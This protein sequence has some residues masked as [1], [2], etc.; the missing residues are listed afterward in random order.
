M[1]LATR[2][3]P[4]LSWA[5][6]DSTRNARVLIFDG[7][8]TGGFEP[9]W[10]L[11]VDQG[12]PWLVL[13]FDLP[14]YGL[15]QWCV[16]TTVRA[17]ERFRSPLAELETGPLD[18]SD[19]TAQWVSVAVGTAMTLS[20]DAAPIGL[21][22]R[23][24]LTGQGLVRAFIDGHPV[25]PHALDPSRTDITRALY[26]T[27]DVT[28]LITPGAHRLDLAVGRG[29]WHTTGF[30]PR[31]LA[32]LR[33]GAGHNST[34]LTRT[35]A[36]S[37]SILSRVIVDEPYYREVHDLRS[38]RWHA[39]AGSAAEAARGHLSPTGMIPT[40]VLP[41]PGPEIGCS[42]TLAAT[43]L[44]SADGLTRV[45]D[46]GVNIAGTSSVRLRTGTSCATVRVV[47][48]EHRGAD[49]RVDTTNLRL[50][51]DADRER[52]VVEYIVDQGEHLLEPWFSYHGFRYVEITGV[53]LDTPLHV[54][55]H[56]IHSLIEPAVALDSDSPTVVRLD[57]VARRTL[58]NTV[59]GM[60]E[61]CPTREQAG[62]TGDTAAVVEYEFAAFDVEA[63]HRKWLGDL[64][65]SQAANGAVPA[66]APHIG[67]A[68]PSDPVWGAALPRV[69]HAHWMRYGDPSVLRDH[70]PALRAWTRFLN[71]C[72]DDRGVVANAPISY[73]HDWLGLRQTPPALLHTAA[74]IEAFEILADLEKY[75]G[76]AQA[77]SAAGQ[78]ARD[79]R[80]AARDVFVR[81]KPFSV[82]NGSQG[83][84]ATAI[85]ANLL[86]EGERRTAGRRL[87]AAIRREGGRLTSGFAATR[88]VVQALAS[89]GADQV[90]FDLL[91]MREEPGVGAMLGNSLGTFWECWWIDPMNTGTGSLDHIGLG[92]AFAGWLWTSLLG[93]RV[94]A[95][96]CAVARIDP[97]PVTG[98]Q[99]LA[100]T[101]LTVRGPLEIAWRQEPTRLS[102]EVDVPF[103]MTAEIV[104]GSRILR[105]G[106]GRHVL[107]LN[108][109][110]PAPVSPLP[111]AAFTLPVLNTGDADVDREQDLLGLATARGSVQGLARTKWVLTPGP[112]HCRPVP[113]EQERGPILTLTG[114]REA[115]VTIDIDL[116]LHDAQF[117]AIKMDT[118]LPYDP[119]ALEPVLQLISA[120]GSSRRSESRLWPAGWSRVALDVTDWGGRSSVVR[121]VAGVRSLDATRARVGVH[122]ASL[123]WS[124]RPRRW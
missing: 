76:H 43:E 75:A 74:A 9:R 7:T 66:I 58:L 31:V 77:A 70:L 103:S 32:E 107:A 48:G 86:T 95:P 56:R 121:I 24:H 34:C 81:R 19:W 80:S 91:S 5:C 65:T 45:F 47:H 104:D 57:E 4:R 113:H 88:A 63:F 120:D 51:T 29:Q 116:D 85:T 6:P 28:D 73:G 16:E 72:R 90:V 10:E 8:A 39:A 37:G 67:A 64:A 108:R 15:W 25:N 38:S 68:I 94:T 61:D 83:S 54:E 93:L 40:V 112:L 69:L 12:T 55:A 46:V 123:G 119:G 96:G 110:Q 114:E 98:V 30:D 101:A 33:T 52:Q 18:L 78:A 36:R 22:V 13:P 42:E 41:D 89:V 111:P 53:P 87:V 49:G 106:A 27:Y 3:R 44:P 109:A 118:D 26:R 14:S 17:G 102:L 11:P 62:W 2:A 79:I 92:G 60:P 35:G 105:V 115:V 122:L 59:H 97:R 124:S 82:A 21:P 1:P 100:G 50:P 23:L 84:Y 71:S 99:R 20:F 117:V